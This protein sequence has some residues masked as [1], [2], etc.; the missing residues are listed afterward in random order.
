LL[1]A[2][3]LYVD[4]GYMS[5]GDPIP[6]IAG[7]AIHLGISRETVHSWAKDENKQQFSDIVKD[8][9]AH[10]ERRLFAGGLDGTFNAS[11]TKLALTKH[12]YTDKSENTIQGGDSPLTIQAPWQVV[13]VKGQ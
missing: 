7:L 13:G 3:K 4:G 2:A 8:L 9:M 6:M 10:Q 11:I 12:G 5:Q 1:E